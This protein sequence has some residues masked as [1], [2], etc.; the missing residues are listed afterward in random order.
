MKKVKCVSIL[1][2]Q[3]MFD[4]PLSELLKECE[5][6]GVVQVLSPKEYISYQQIKFW[7]G[8]L[9]PKLAENGDPVNWWENTLKFAVMP[10]EFTPEIVVVKGREYVTIPSIT[11]LGIKK[12]NQ[13]IEGSVAYCRDT[14][15]LDWVH[16]PESDLKKL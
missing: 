3:P 6:G 11:K 12:M 7:K 8:V 5:V 15:G 2:G 14:L 13:L 10:D 1:E 9:L 4:A 16:L